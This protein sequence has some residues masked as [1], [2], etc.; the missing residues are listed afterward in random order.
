MF[1]R[2]YMLIGIAALVAFGVAQHRG[3]SP[4]DSYANTTPGSSSGSRTYH[5]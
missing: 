4:F 1:H 2:L 3:T 5:K